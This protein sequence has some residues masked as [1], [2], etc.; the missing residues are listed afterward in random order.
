MVSFAKARRDIGGDGSGGG[1][2]GSEDPPP[3][4]PPWRLSTPGVRVHED[5]GPAVTAPASTRGAAGRPSLR[6]LRGVDVRYISLAGAGKNGRRIL[7]KALLPEGEDLGGRVIVEKAIPIRKSDEA[8]RMVYGVV[9]APDSP[10]ADGHLMEPA[11]IEKALHGFMQ[12]GRVGQVDTNHDENAGR[13]NGV[14]YVAECWLTKAVG[15]GDE[16]AVVDPLFAEEPEG[17]WCV[18]IKVTDD[19]A[20]ASVEKGEITGLSMAGVGVEE[21]LTEEE[22]ERFAP[23][24][25]KAAGLST[26]PL[27][28]TGTKRRSLIEKAKEL[29]AQLIGADG[30]GAEG[31]EE[32]GASAEGAGSEH[33]AGASGAEDATRLVKSFRAKLLRSQLWQIT[34]ALSGGIREVLEDDDVKDKA[35]A[36]RALVDEFEEWLTGE[37]KMSKAEDTPTGGESAGTDVLVREVKELVKAVESLRAERDALAGRIERME[38]QRLGRRSHLG[39]SIAGDGAEGT[40]DLPV[41]KGRGLPIL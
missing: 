24:F 28:I 3:T 17:T 1:G 31:A 11:E 27:D 18:G 30:V 8:K 4:P 20:W 13:D 23:A 15:E 34:E 40:A 35:A 36:V 41:K 39:D 2:G 10:D 16:R 25:E 26:G 14:G 21:D 19:G 37:V 38:A 5:D 9:Y 6:R 12:A 7:A 22:A 32:P 29:L 33:A